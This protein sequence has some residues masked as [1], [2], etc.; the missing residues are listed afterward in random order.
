MLTRLLICGPAW[1]IHRGFL[2]HQCLYYLFKKFTCSLIIV[3]FNCVLRILAGWRERNQQDATNLIFI[4]KLLF[5][6]VSGINMPIFRRTR[7][8]STAYGVLHWLC[9]LWLCGAGTRVVCTV[10]KLSL[11]MKMGIMMPETCWDRSLTIN[12][13]LV[14]SCWFLSLHPT[15]MMHF[16]KSLKYILQ[17]TFPLNNTMLL[18][19]PRQ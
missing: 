4:M 6:H 8:C 19:V 2:C 9:W 14:T 11:V 16:H 10:W 12:I 5:Q 13:K 18:S 17:L 3:E 15:F 1:N 7:L